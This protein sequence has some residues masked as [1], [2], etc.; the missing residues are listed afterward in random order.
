MLERGILAP[1]SQEFTMFNKQRPEQKWLQFCIR[2]FLMHSIQWRSLIGDCISFIRHFWKSTYSNKIIK[3]SNAHFTRPCTL[4]HY[5]MVGMAVAMGIPGMHEKLAY[6]YAVHGNLKWSM[7]QNLI[8][9]IARN[10]AT[11]FSKCY[12]LHNWTELVF[13]LS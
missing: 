11:Q 12:F 5:N 2:C 1:A 3:R 7:F 6:I 9:H 8:V 13:K 10:R 4:C